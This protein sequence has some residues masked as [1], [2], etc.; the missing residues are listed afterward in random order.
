[1]GG[2]DSLRS[3]YSLSV[4]FFMMRGFDWL[5]AFSAISWGF[6][7]DV[8]GHCRYFFAGFLSSFAR[9]L[10]QKKGSLVCRCGVDS[11]YALTYRIYI[12]WEELLLVVCFV[13]FVYGRAQ[14]VD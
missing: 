14:L 9:T 11:R 2:F 6:A 8:A 3:H 12:S 5:G 1:M 10:G 7:C 4:L 13:T